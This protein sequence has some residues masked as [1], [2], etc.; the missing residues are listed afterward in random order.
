MVQKWSLAFGRA[1]PKRRAAGLGRG[2][3]KRRAGATAPGRLVPG[4]GRAD[5]MRR[6]AGLG[7]ASPKRRAG[8]AAPGRLV[9]G[10]GRIDKPVGCIQVTDWL[11]GTTSGS[12]AVSDGLKGKIGY[13]S[14]KSSFGLK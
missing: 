3:P 5:P 1:D 11:I 10:P 13:F 7:R 6:A 2:D 8:A 4:P 14:T 12:A 9:P